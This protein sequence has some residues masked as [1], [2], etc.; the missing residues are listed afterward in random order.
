MSKYILAIDQGTTSSRA[1]LFDRQSNHFNWG[2]YDRSKSF[3]RLWSQYRTLSFG[4]G[5]RSILDRL[6]NS[7]QSSLRLG[8]GERSNSSKS[9]PLQS[10]SVTKCRQSKPTLKS[11][12]FFGCLLCTNLNARSNT[13]S[14]PRASILLDWPSIETTFGKL[15]RSVIIFYKV[16]KS[17]RGSAFKVLAEKLALLVPFIFSYYHSYLTNPMT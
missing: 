16:I 9:C 17:P 7:H 12:G 10:S 14:P 13:F 1:I 11:R 15:V 2:V 5:E 4:V 6:L 8:Y 3:R